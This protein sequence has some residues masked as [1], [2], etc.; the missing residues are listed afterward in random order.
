[1]K[2]HLIFLLCIAIVNAKLVMIIRHGEKISNAVTNLSPEGEARAICLL[3]VFG[4][5]GTYVSPQ[6][7][8]AQNPTLRRRSTR[9]R[10]TVIPLAKSLGLQ[11]DLSYT[12]RK[13][14]KLVEDIMNSPEEVILVSWSK[15][16]IPEIA[17]YLGVENPPKWGKHF[18]KIW[19]ISDGRTSYFNDFNDKNK[20]N[21]T[22]NIVETK[23]FDKNNSKILRI[24]K[25]GD[26]LDNELSIN[27]HSFFA[28]TND[29]DGKDNDKE[30]NSPVIFEILK[31]NI[32]DCMHKKMK[33]IKNNNH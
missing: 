12:S 23:K 14:Q 3:N 17:S 4:T 9:P 32:D 11:V 28:N 27:T 25:G 7:I 18:D 13:T 1:M 15:Q 19:M 33:E 21:F 10:D 16:R 8:F 30:R 26:D 6:K 5:N 29:S 24:Q 20:N 2:F 31:Q 22:D